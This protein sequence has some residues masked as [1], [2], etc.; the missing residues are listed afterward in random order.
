MFELMKCNVH[1]WEPVSCSQDKEAV[2][3]GPG[4][5]ADLRGLLAIANPPP[6]PNSRPRP[7]SQAHCV[8]QPG[9]QTTCPL[10]TD[11]SRRA[12]AKG[13]SPCGIRDRL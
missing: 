1:S 4:S 11:P 8:L 7:D 12:H 6:P 13:V 2:T 10:K 5:G 9:P 3:R